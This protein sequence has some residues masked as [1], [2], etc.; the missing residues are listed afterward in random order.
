MCNNTKDY[1]SWEPEKFNVINFTRIVK[2]Q[3]KF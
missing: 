3:V 1:F 2:T